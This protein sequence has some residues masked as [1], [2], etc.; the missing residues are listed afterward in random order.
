MDE[1]DLLAAVAARVLERVDDDPLAAES[2]DDRD[3]LSRSAARIDVVLDTGIQVF[4]VLA[5]DHEV[6]AREPR[7]HTGEGLDRPDVGVEVELLP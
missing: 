2:R 4:G 1:R 3:R 7:R 5:H 6:D